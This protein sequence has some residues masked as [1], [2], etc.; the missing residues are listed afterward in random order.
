MLEQ[1][2]VSPSLPFPGATWKSEKSSP[3]GGRGEEGGVQKW[4]ALPGAPESTL[5]SDICGIWLV[6][7]SWDPLGPLSSR[8]QEDPRGLETPPR[9]DLGA[10]WEATSGQVGFKITS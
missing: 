4:T 6:M 5:E 7:A 10:F 9:I 2:L 1:L 3:E 8:P